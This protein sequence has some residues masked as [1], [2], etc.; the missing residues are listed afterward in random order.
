MTT[1][2]DVVSFKIPNHYPQWLVTW[3]GPTPAECVPIWWARNKQ[4]IREAAG[5]SKRV[6]KL[7]YYEVRPR[8]MIKHRALQL[9][10]LAGFT[11]RK[12]VGTNEYS[13][14]VWAV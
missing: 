14:F 4:E 6:R 9:I 1:K 8:L 10:A 13:D 2:L 12:E 11:T 7:Y 5:E 3:G